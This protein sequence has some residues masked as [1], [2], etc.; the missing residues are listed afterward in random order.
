LKG[1]DG[2][3][4]GF[5]FKVMNSKDSKNVHLCEGIH[6]A[7]ECVRTACIDLLKLQAWI[8][9]VNGKFYE[10]VDIKPTNNGVDGSCL[11]SKQ[12]L[13]RVLT[14]LPGRLLQGLKYDSDLLFDAGFKLGHVSSAL[15]SFH[16]EAFDGHRNIWQTQEVSSVRDFI[17][18]ALSPEEEING[19]NY[20]S[21]IE[22]VI[23][24]FELTVPPLFE[25]MTPCQVHGDFN[26][27][28][29]LVRKEN[30]NGNE[31]Y[32]LDGL[33]DFGDTSQGYL[34]FEVAI[35][36]AYFMYHPANDVPLKDVGGWILKGYL[37]TVQ[38]NE[39]DWGAIIASIGA[40]LAVSLVMG[41]YSFKMNPD[42]TYLLTHQ[43][44][45]WDVLEKFSRLKHDCVIKRWKEI[46]LK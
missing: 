39:A 31:R 7:M 10:V 37:K 15:L 20:R 36:I 43:R 13:L 18:E 44:K 3:E 14:F 9:S 21:L 19:K 8:P 24:D 16:H 27:G 25:K 22:T 26:D 40:R 42:N 17:K 2:A 35:A 5:V 34:S 4:D 28:N 33:L 45:G 12:H 6:A 11:R 38:L 1:I 41:A 29:I 23:N 32:V 46:V 30:F